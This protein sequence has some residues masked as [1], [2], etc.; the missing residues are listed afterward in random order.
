MSDKELTG[1]GTVSESKQVGDKVY[2]LFIKFDIA[3][4]STMQTLNTQCTRWIQI[5]CLT[6]NTGK[7]KFQHL[8]NRKEKRMNKKAILIKGV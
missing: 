7:R 6:R 2:R 8:Q 1:R 5:T 4:A 3:K